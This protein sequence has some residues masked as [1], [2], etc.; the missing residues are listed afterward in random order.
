MEYEDGVFTRGA[1]RG[2]GGVGDDITLNL[3]TIANLPLRLFSTFPAY[4]T[5]RGEV[6]LPRKG[7][8]MLNER[9]L[10]ERL[11]AFANTKDFYLTLYSLSNIIQN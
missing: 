3:K 11:P 9:R 8:S 4:L 5:V 2:D 10:A 6:Y 7:L 1:T